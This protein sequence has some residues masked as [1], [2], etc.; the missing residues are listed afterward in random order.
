MV[1]LIGFVALGA[2]WASAADTTA[3][4]RSVYP[5]FEEA[6]C[7]GCHVGDGVASATR[8][9]FPEPGAPPD[10]IEAFGKSLVLLIDAND[11]GNSLLLRKP[12]NRIPHAGGQR[13]VPG[14]PEETAVRA[15]I[16]RL[17]QLKG[18]DLA[19]ARRYRDEERRAAMPPGRRSPSGA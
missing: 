19:K 9:Q 10:R 3:F 12:T 18:E 15:W 6:G 5:I 16:D 2:V 8:L 7:R 14:S 13:I 17:T 11:P 1:R 4:W